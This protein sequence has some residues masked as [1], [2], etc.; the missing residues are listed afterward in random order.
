LLVGFY[1]TGSGTPSMTWS[2][3]VDEA[4]CVGWIDGVRRRVDD[5]RYTIRFTPRK[6]SSTWSAINIERV[7][8]LTELGKM[9]PE[10]KAAYERRIAA[11][12]RT[13]SYEQEGVSGLSVSELATFKENPDAFA[14][15]ETQPLSYRKKAIW[16]VV[17]AKKQETREL[18]FQTLIRASSGKRR[19]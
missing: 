16:W 1:K 12:S 13:Y 15:F 17:S 9:K 11:K 8:I 19:I 14:F 18:R 6:A 4:L 7:R 10:G 2:E 3:A 5:D